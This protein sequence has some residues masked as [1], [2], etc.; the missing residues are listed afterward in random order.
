[1][2]AAADTLSEALIGPAGYLMPADDHRQ[3]GAA[4]ITLCVEDE[5]AEDLGR[6]AA[7]RAQPWT[8]EAYRNAILKTL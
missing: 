2:V 8:A 7:Q 6:Q 4:L 5:M 3:M 1:V